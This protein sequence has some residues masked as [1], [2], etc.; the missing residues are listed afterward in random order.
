[1][2]KLLYRLGLTLFILGGA[3]LLVAVH[4]Y[5]LITIQEAHCRAESDQLE[6][7]FQESIEPYYGKSVLDFPSREYLDS[8][9]SK[10]PQLKK[11]RLKADPRGRVTL[12]YDLKRP[13]VFV[14]LDRIYGLT[15]RGELVPAGGGDYP[16]VTGVG[17]GNTQLYSLLRSDKLAY[18]LKIASLCR[19]YDGRNDVR[20]STID[21]DHK[22]GLSM[23]I[24]GCRA[25][26]ILGRGNEKRK[27][28]RLTYL[29]DYLCSFSDD[30]ESIDFRFSNQLVLRKVN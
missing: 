29:A 2:K 28:E 9:F 21:L 4:H 3:A 13:I 1:M 5:D 22:S 7:P 30:I 10:Y 26:L 27:F 23:H 6:I 16:I 19:E 14:Q 12:D 24:E 11:A 17:G 15:A 25:E 18:L 20:I 8:L